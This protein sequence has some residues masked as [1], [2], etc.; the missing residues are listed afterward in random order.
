MNM[1]LFLKSILQKK[2]WMVLLF[3][4]FSTIFPSVAQLAEVGFSLGGFNY[5]GDL[6]RSYRP[7]T[8]RP[9]GSIFFRQNLS[10]PLSVRFG[11]TG[12][13]VYGT[14]DEPIDP[15]AAQRMAD[16]NIFLVEASSLLEYHFFDYKS[17][18][19]LINWSPYLV[20]G[21][22]I[23]TFFGEAEKNGSYSKVQPSIPIGLGFKYLVSPRIILGV[24]YVARKTFFDYLDNISEGD[25]RVKNYQYGNWYTN[26][27]YYHLGFS[28]NY[29]F[30]EIPCP[31]KFQ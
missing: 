4:S 5:T 2:K 30:Y 17:E 27:W 3:L 14:D 12:G 29:T 10:E 13:G 18:K 1:N 31:Y 9:A 21:L 7:L 6:I 20:G 28:I 26:D 8:T 24:E 11:L 15:F 25:V 23:F 19:S 16:F 22:G